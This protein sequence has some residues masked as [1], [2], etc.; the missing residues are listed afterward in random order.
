VSAAAVCPKCGSTTP[1]EPGAGPSRCL[2]CGHPLTLSVELAASDPQM[3]ATQSEL[4]PEECEPA[5]AALISD[6]REAFGFDPSGAGPAQITDD[7][8]FGSASDSFSRAIA[9][10]TLGPHSRLGD[11]EILEELG[12]GGMGI[13][14]RARQISLG[15]EVALKVLP[16]Y[17]RYGPV[18]VQ[19]FRAEAQAA[20]RIHHTNVVSIYA[21]GEHNGHFYYAMELVDGVGLDTVI[22]GCPE[23]LS[24]A[25]A[26]SSSG[27]RLKDPG[28]APLVKAASRADSSPNDAQPR[29]RP[30][31]TRADYRHLAGLLAEVADALECAHRE[32]V[33]HRDVKP[34][35]LL[36]GS[37]N[38]LHLT[39]FG[40]ARMTD[41]PHLTIS[42]EIMGT[43]AYLSPEQ[44]RGQIDQIDHRTDIYSLGVTLYEVITGRKPFDGPTREQ[45]I[46]AI[47]TQDPAPPR[48]V[49]P[50]IPVELE[51][52]CLR[53]IEKDPARR[54]PRAGLLAE[55][56]RRFA[57]GRPILSRRTPRVVRAAKWVRRHPTISA[58][59]LATGATVALAIGLL[60]TLS[61]MRQEQARQLLTRA[62]DQLVYNDYRH[63]EL[64]A[65]D[66]KLAE[67]LGA[68]PLQLNLVAGLAA[69]GADDQ[70]GAISHLEAVLEQEPTDLRA[71]YLLA[72]AQ[73]RERFTEAARTTFERAEQL[74]QSGA[75]RMT[76]D[77]W[78]FRGLAIHRQDP[79]AAIES[80]RQANTLRAQE[81]GFHPQAVL[82]LARAQNQ[83]MYASRTLDDLSEI[84]AGLGQLIAQRHY[85]AYPYYLLSITHRL[86]A[87]IYQGS[88]GARDDT[89]DECYARA[90]ELARAGQE[91]DP[92]DDRPVT[93]EAEC[94]ESLGRYAEAIEARTRAINLARQS[95]SQWEGYH[96]RWRLRYWQGQYQAALQDLAACSSYDPTNRL[97]LHVYP[98]LVCAEAGDMAT[99][100]HHAR[101]LAD[102]PET[103][104]QAVLWSATC[105][106]LLGQK[107][108]AE[109]LLSARASSVD[110]AAELVPPQTEQWVRELYTHCLTGGPATGLEELAVA[111]AGETGA[112]W[113]LSGEADFH[114]GV[115]LLAAGDRERARE[116]LLKA[117]R[118]FDSEQRYTYHAKL[119]L[120]PMEGNVNSRV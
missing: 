117:Y 17:L 33:I 114:A 89:V 91:A 32:G 103:S 86:E 104:A 21:Q 58:A 11:F 14:Y 109:A 119:L 101:A 71:L 76:P 80:Y 72:W 83:R 93:A 18:A 94:L 112:P 54:H 113:K 53:A 82:H 37:D 100:L 111:L 26:G 20:A 29:T 60:W 64:V 68:D 70:V 36:L 96:Y 55:D 88:R 24:S 1:V 45:I 63:P 75:G 22:R 105:L 4:T 102:H 84:K 23:L 49:N 118:S 74:R 95:R 52:I 13:V 6:L 97:Y 79:A 108:E 39:D 50:E 48:R 41:Q 38:R 7:G 98:A 44:I 46:S 57:L 47:C 56:L 92:S 5:E 107:E 3:E 87:E 116:R 59:I 110:F 99:A 81:H 73:G 28:A 8:E 77:A 19:R 66:I 43:P 30:H 69:L 27:I 90:L 67:A 10:P 16:E 34:H 120:V 106:R 40:L 78:F 25:A 42:G 85:G 35:N 61:Q 51:T 31:W 115:M 65:S 15:R 62:Y 12:R 2:R 9:R